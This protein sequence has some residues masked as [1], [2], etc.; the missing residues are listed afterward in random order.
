MLVRYGQNAE[1]KQVRQALVYT[2]DEHHIAPEKIDIEAVKI[3][4]RLNSQGFEAYIVGGAVR[5]LLIGHVPKDFDIATSA[6]PSKIRKM[7]RNSR[8]IGRRFRLVHI[9]FGEKIYEVSTFRS[10]EDGSIGNKFGT[11]DE[12]VHRR[13]FTLNALYYDPIHELVIDYVGGVKDIRAKK[14]KPIIPLQ[15][16]FSEDPVRMIRAIKYAAMT[17]SSIPFFVQLQIRKNAYLLEFVS[18]SRITEEINKI[19]FSGH[20]SDIIKKLLDFKLYVY[21]Q[22]GACAFIDSSSKFKKMYLENLALLDKEANSKHQIKQGECLKSLLKDY[23]KLIA[24][25]EGLPQEVYTYVYKECRHFI[26][27]MNPQR[28]E[29]EFAVKST[30]NDLGIKVSMERS[31]PRP[32]K[33]GKQVKHV[34]RK[35]KTKRQE[36][37]KDTD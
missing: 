37:Q 2:K 20:S 1:G 23:I 34:R 12:D 21:L 31:Q 27:P 28:R 8:V 17:D 29:L 9:F 33:L 19:V 15:L 4:Q 25:P 7:F 35:K 14:I 16:I 11:I 24:D 30:L 26:L 3:I 6:E 5:D 13:D 18:P 36:T 22:P 32:A 10:T